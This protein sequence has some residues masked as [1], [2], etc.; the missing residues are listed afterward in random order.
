LE[1][2]TIAVR[3]NVTKNKNLATLPLRPDTAAQ[4]RVFLVGK[5]RDAPVF[6]VPVNTAPMIKADEADA[7]IPYV[8]EEGRYADFHALRHT[9]GS[10]LAA[11]N[12]HP[13]IA[14]S[15]MRHSDINLT[16]SRYTH[17]FKGQEAEAVARFPDL[18]LSRCEEQEEESD[19]K[20]GHKG[21]LGDDLPPE[22]GEQRI[23]TN[24]SEQTAPPDG[25]ENSIFAITDRL[26]NEKIRAV[27]VPTG[28]APTIQ[29]SPPR[30]D[31]ELQTTSG[32]SG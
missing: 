22:A 3:Q 26:Q 24:S 19:M 30:H 29:T 11:N 15:I 9:T 28:V 1:A 21:S 31:I 27:G 14:Q 17:V 4:L 7:G 18:S 10:W 20:V 25:S 8:D 12:V 5:K 13:K 6:D 32:T 23:S 16:M 2:H